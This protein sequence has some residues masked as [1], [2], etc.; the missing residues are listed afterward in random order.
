MD[1][2]TQRITDLE[3]EIKGYISDLKSA[4]TA[5]EKSELRGLIKT[6]RETLINERKALPQGTEI[7]L[8]S[9]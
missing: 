9:I 6:S 5:A 8:W 1:P 2:T 4:S 3:E 7:Y